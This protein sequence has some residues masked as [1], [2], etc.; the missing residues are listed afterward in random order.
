MTVEQKFTRWV[1]LSVLL[2]IAVFAYFLLADFKM[3]L[4]P[5]A[6]VVRNVVKVVPQVSGNIVDLQVENNQAVQ[7]G[8]VLFSIDPSV[9]ELA[10]E[11]AELAVEQAQ[12]QNEQIDASILAA[13]ADVDAIKIVYQQKQQYAKRL[14][15]LFTSSSV[16]QQQR[17]DAQSAAVAEH[18]KLLAAEARLKQLQVNRGK[19]GDSNLNLQ[20]AQNQ[21]KQA[22]LNLSYTE[23]KAEQDGVVTNV[24]LAVGA[25]ANAGQPLL[26][27]V[28]SESEVIADFR[29]KSSRYA[30]NGSPALVTFDSQPGTL[31]QAEVVG[32]DAGVSDGQ[33]D[34]NGRLATPANSNRWVRDAQRM[35]L[36]L[37]VKQADAQFLPS[38]A[39]ATVQLLPQQ[40]VFAYLAR[41]QLK[42]LSL[43]HYI[44]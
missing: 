10:V 24:Q 11:R 1:K 43:L 27:L 18:A 14:A 30:V 40:P 21:L 15:A 17:D 33:F 5:Q 20:V 26:A 9:Y 35:R 32:M 3:P 34:A 4:T 42:F 7:R 6:M 23:V 44:Y 22:R 39:K 36:H 31:Y 25:Y 41:L 13:I 29:E 16:S 19:L 2:F 28:S 12:Q 37:A 8:D 38:G